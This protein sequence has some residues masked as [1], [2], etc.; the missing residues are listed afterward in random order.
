M[1][2]RQ[3]A[4][5]RLVELRCGSLPKALRDS[6]ASGFASRAEAKLKQLARRHITSPIVAHH[7]LDFLKRNKEGGNDYLNFAPPIESID[8]AGTNPPSV[9]IKS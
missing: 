7:F 1:T 3:I 5:E 4:L 9:I 6:I 2:A 8:I